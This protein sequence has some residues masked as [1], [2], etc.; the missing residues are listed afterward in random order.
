MNK[1][2]IF[3]KELL[4]DINKNSDRYRDIDKDFVSSINL[5]FG[6]ID[7]VKAE[8]IT[9]NVRT[10]ATTDNKLF[11]ELAIECDSEIMNNKKL[12]IPSS[13]ERASYTS[14]LEVYVNFPPD[15]LNITSELKKEIIN[16]LCTYNEQTYNA[17]SERYVE[18]L[19]NDLTKFELFN[20]EL[21]LFALCSKLSLTYNFG[22]KSEELEHQFKETKEQIEQIDV[23]VCSKLLKGSL[24]Q[25]LE[26]ENEFQIER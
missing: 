26:K 1:F 22:F 5:L 4:L 17:M 10:F 18:S 9:G 6:E 15:K 19:K 21:E 20:K 14:K 24:A 23:E 25:R 7:F 2:K 12:Y 11:N 3:N 13:V 8:V 16:G